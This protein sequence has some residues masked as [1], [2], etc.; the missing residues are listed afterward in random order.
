MVRNQND[1]VWWYDDGYEIRNLY[2]PNGK[3]KSRPQNMQYYFKE[4]ITWSALTSKKLSLRITNQGNIITGAG[5]GLF[6]EKV[7]LLP[8]MGILN[9]IVIERLVKSLSQ[10]LNFEVGVLEQI[11]IILSDNDNVEK[12][13]KE[14]IQIEKMIGILLK[15]VGILQNIH[16]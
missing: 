2:N 14:N 9:S 11:P 7:S 8:I 3:L 1:V 15:Q 5:Y 13:V 10:T 16:Y 12:V 4:G 6:N